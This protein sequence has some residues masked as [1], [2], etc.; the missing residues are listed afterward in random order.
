MLERGGEYFRELWKS[1]TDGDLLAAALALSQSPPASSRKG[2]S[3][4]AGQSRVAK[5]GAQRDFAENTIQLRLSSA[6]SP[7]IC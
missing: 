3:H 7:R 4:S 2:N 1:L 6:F 5:A